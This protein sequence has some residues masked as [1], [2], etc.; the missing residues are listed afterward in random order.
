MEIDKKYNLDKVSNYNKLE[1]LL[2]KKISN[3]VKEFIKGKEDIIGF[4]DMYYKKYNKN[5]DIDKYELD[6]SLLINKNGAIYE[7]LDD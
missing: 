1:E 7:V 3:D 4:N 6:V 5:K 2:S